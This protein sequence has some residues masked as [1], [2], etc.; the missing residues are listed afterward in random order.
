M[1]PEK[2]IE[3]EENTCFNLKAARALDTERSQ[4]AVAQPAVEFRS[5]SEHEIVTHPTAEARFTS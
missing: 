1:Q 5:A 3:D 4:S 2:L